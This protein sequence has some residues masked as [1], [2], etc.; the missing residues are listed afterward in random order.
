[1]L[2]DNC[3]KNEAIISYTKMSG[4]NIEE[5]HLCA[6]C[7]EKKMKEDL[8]FN[9]VVSSQVDSFLKELFKLTGNYDKEFVKK[10][11]PNCGTTFDELEKGHLGCEKCYDIFSSEISGI[12]NSLM[13]S[14]KH[15]GKIPN[16]AGHEVKLKREE[17]DLNQELKIAIEMEEYEKAAILRDKLKALREIG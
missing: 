12:L 6:S 7:A 11:C 8:I 16:S 3:K 15:K 13:Y 17:E 9:Q 2:C 14:S 10:T 1:M 4:N 5:V